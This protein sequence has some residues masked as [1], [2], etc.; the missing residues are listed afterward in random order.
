MLSAVLFGHNLHSI[1]LEDIPTVKPLS[2]QCSM[3]YILA[4][5]QEEVS[6]S[7]TTIK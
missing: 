7:T 2:I 1:N 5:H 4:L 6:A 3:T